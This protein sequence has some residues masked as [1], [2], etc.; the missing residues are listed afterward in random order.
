[1]KEV[2]N[3]LVLQELRKLNCR[4]VHFWGSGTPTFLGALFDEKFSKITY[5]SVPGFNH[6]TVGEAV[7]MAS[8]R[9]VKEGY[10]KADAWIVDVPGLLL[11][12]RKD[13]DRIRRKV[14]KALFL[15]NLNQSRLKIRG[16][17]FTQKSSVWMG[18]PVP[19]PPFHHNVYVIELVPLVASAK[20]VAKLNPGRNPSKPCL[21]VGMTGLPVEQRFENHKRGHKDSALVRKYGIGLRPEFYEQLN[22]MS[23]RG[24]VWMEKKLTAGLRS[25]GYTVIGGT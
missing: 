16:F 2:V 11:T 20:R 24:A 21:Y 8:I 10:P 3:D 15:L 17:R 22:P 6:E 25:H 9:V 19:V 12:I 1:M 4:S 23:E 13:R 7:G 14:R 5:S 18:T